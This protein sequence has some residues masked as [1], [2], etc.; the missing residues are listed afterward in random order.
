MVIEQVVQV[1]GMD[2]RVVQK[3]CGKQEIVTEGSLLGQSITLEKQHGCL[4]I[5][6]DFQSLQVWASAVTAGPTYR[7]SDTEDRQQLLQQCSSTSVFLFRQSIRTYHTFV[8][9]FSVHTTTH[10]SY[11]STYSASGSVG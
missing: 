11:T 8:H 2:Q 5:Q 7:L 10:C 4:E 1:K 6:L 9:T 3:N